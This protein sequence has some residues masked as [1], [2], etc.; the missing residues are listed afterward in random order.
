[1]GLSMNPRIACFIVAIS[2]VHTFAGAATA[3]PSERPPNIIV[4]LTDDQRWDALGASGN[5]I[6]QTP[7]MDRLAHEGVYF[8]NNYSTT[9]ICC[10]SRASILT[11]MYARRHGV[12]DFGTELTAPHLQLSYPI[13]LR[14][15]GYRTAF[16]G[17]Y[18]VGRIHPKDRFDFFYGLPGNRRYVQE[19]DGEM[20][21]M[22][23]RLTDQALAFLQDSPKNELFCLSISYR[24]PHSEDY[25]P[26]PYPPPPEMEALYQHVTIP[27]PTL[28]TETHYNNL[29]DFLKNSEGR[30]RWDNRFRTP[31]RFQESARDYY[32]MVSGLDAALGRITAMLDQR[33]LAEN[34]III[35]T[36]DNGAFLGERGLAGKWYAYED[37]IR[38]PLIIHDPRAETN[39]KRRVINE[40]VLNIDL[41]PTIYAYAGLNV[42]KEMDGENLQPLLHDEETPW[43]N[44]W[45]FEHRFS[46]PGIPK[47]EGVVTAD[48]KFFRW[49]EQSGAPEELY[50]VA[51][52]PLE[53]NN[54]AS[55]SNH[56]EQLNRLKKRFDN[57]EAAIP[58]R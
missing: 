15:N 25:D 47:S 22:T 29:P 55:A 46:H 6:I 53:V 4:F 23:N 58:K 37:S 48:W 14:E 45:Y 32:R 49:Y 31:E 41:A 51:T 27:M 38:T 9:P 57:F 20:R 56:R 24:A 28:A 18:G 40:I 5:A 35:F 39:A 52:D 10:T 42:P 17:K 43:R 50:N 33:D 3:Q 54:L 30:K 16:V 2:A 7:N 26:R 36:S 11:G 1:M 13:V 21:H 8:R 12:H 19:V 44:S 34:T